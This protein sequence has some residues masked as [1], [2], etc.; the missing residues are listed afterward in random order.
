M[1]VN[2]KPIVDKEIEDVLEELKKKTEKLLN[3]EIQNKISV[4][5]LLFLNKNRSNSTSPSDLMI[6]ES[7]K[8]TVTSPVTS[9]IEKSIS[10]EL[11]KLKNDKNN[12]EKTSVS[13]KCQ[14]PNVKLAVINNE[15]KGSFNALNGLKNN[16]QLSNNLK[17]QVKTN[18]KTSKISTNILAKIAS[19]SNQKKERKLLPKS[20]L[21]T[22]S[23][24]INNLNMKP[25]SSFKLQVKTTN[26]LVTSA[27]STSSLS[28]NSNI[29]NFAVS[30]DM[31]KLLPKTT[32]ST[33]EQQSLPLI[34]PSVSN[35][36][37][38]ILPKRI[39]K[40][41]P[42]NVI[43]S[44]S[45]TTIESTAFVKK[46]VNEVIAN[47]RSTNATISDFNSMT[48]TTNSIDTVMSGVLQ[49]AT[50]SAEQS[51]ADFAT[52]SQSLPILKSKKKS[53]TRTR[54]IKK[55]FLIF[56][57]NITDFLERMDLKI[58]QIIMNKKRYYFVVFF[59]YQKQNIFLDFYK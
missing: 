2:V 36:K 41:K 58:S 53:L 7:S 32:Q 38:V 3:N 19:K 34:S 8:N 22:N 23:N 17:L 1:S 11:S 13:I 14:T 42:I 35:I 40:P 15:N 45:S 30:K 59:N 5:K 46:S 16:D 18:Q 49:S 47:L 24:S 37:D 56:F 31:L 57:L 43:A 21:S 44:V 50:L 12:D 52:S 48:K 51:S 26:S 27:S 4:D 6:S 55:F 28:A 10:F 39:N 9:T 54:L 33:Q 25:T 29:I 20:S